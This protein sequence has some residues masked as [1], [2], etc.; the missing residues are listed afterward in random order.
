[1]F[2]DNAGVIVNPKGEMKGSA[3]TGPVAKECVSVV[4]A[5]CDDA[6]FTMFAYSGGSLAAYRIERRYRRI[7]PSHCCPMLVFRMVMTAT[8]LSALHDHDQALRAIDCTNVLVSGVTRARQL[9]SVCGCQA[10]AYC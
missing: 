9:H 3:I 5:F 10:V 8:T 1:M 6:M 7:S 4:L 2:Q